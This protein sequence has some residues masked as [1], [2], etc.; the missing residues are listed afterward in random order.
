MG[1]GSDSGAPPGS[2]NAPPVA[3]AGTDVTID[4]GNSVMLDG[5][6]SLDP[7][8]AALIYVWKQVSGDRI[9]LVG[10]DTARVTFT[11]PDV[12][13]SPTLVFGLTVSDGTQVA[14]DEVSVT[15]NP[16]PD[17]LPPRVISKTPADGATNVARN[18]KIIVQFNE[19]MNEASLSGSMVVRAA[20]T[21]L[22]G[23][24]SYD[25]INFKATFIPNA[26]LAASTIHTVD[27]LS[28]ITDRAGNALTGISWS[29]TTITD[30]APQP[31]AGKDRHVS[32]GSTVNL[33]GSQSSDAETPFAALKFSWRQVA[34][35]PVSLTNAQSATPSFTAPNKVVTLRFE[36][37]VTDTDGNKATDEVQI[38][39]L[40]DAAH[41]VF[42]SGTLGNDI[43]DG[44][45]VKPV[46][47]LDKAISL[48]TRVTSRQSDV[49]VHEGD[50]RLTQTLSMANGV[51]LYG[52]FETSCVLNIGCGGWTRTAT[53]KTSLIGPA[54]AVS[55]IDITTDTVLDGFR[56]ESA[57]GSTG[58]PGANST[59]L[60]VRGGV[61]GKFR[62]TD[63]TFVASRGG[64]ST[65]GTNGAKGSD[66]GAGSKGDNSNEDAVLVNL[67]GSGGTNSCNNNGGG[68]GASGLVWP[69]GSLGKDGVGPNGGSGGGGG[70]I[71]I[72]GGTGGAG[73]NGANGAPGAG[74]N[75]AGFVD[76]VLHVWRPSK[77]GPGGIGGH[78]SGGGGGGG[79]GGQVVGL[80]PGT[81]A[82]GGG[83]GGGGCRGSGGGGGDGGGGSFAIFLSAASPVIANNTIRTGIKVLRGLTLV[84]VGGGDG[85]DGGLG[86]ANA[87][88]G[89]GG[90]GGSGSN[91][92]G[93]GGSGGKGGNGG[94]GGGGGG[95]GGGVSYGIYRAE[96]SVPVISN[97]TFSIGAGGLGSLGGHNGLAGESGQIK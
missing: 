78:G 71:D 39:T 91:E 28:S 12:A 18:A 25:A 92:V 24:L 47:S 30:T 15:V 26:P 46:R 51:S 94:A 14:S 62:I 35:P 89:S 34:G 8:G 65:N 88:G 82:G 95:G 20:G 1:G 5:S 96:G 29:F 37:T 36:L 38:T 55:A 40:E 44:S 17:V 3:I 52:D 45:M 58:N 50:Y 27:L 9:A 11:A 6:A 7:E 64:D 32:W 86:G 90:A 75:G 69:F 68:G 13:V 87:V 21:M 10:A 23:V 93:A 72:D 60:Y 74:G 66:G 42:V 41:A 63:N 73:G 54:T 70:G 33:D 77:G 31:L 59:A 85:G 56:I 67:G 48:A 80:F 57:R 97:N 43:N 4:A 2:T 19:A 79:G 16:R 22:S 53:S 76:D 81:G 84:L 49:Y 83:G 61:G